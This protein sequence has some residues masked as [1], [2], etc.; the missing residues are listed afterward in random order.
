MIMALMRAIALATFSHI[1][2]IY[3]GTLHVGASHRN[4]Q[5]YTVQSTVNAGPTLSFH[6]ASDSPHLLYSL[7]LL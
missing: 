7:A 2:D 1:P 4:T 6:F 3:R 5:V